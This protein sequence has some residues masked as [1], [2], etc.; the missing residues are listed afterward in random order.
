[1]KHKNLTDKQILKTLREHQNILRKY[2]VK[3][4]GLFGSYVRGK[5]KKGSDIDFL[6][7]FIKPDFDNFMDLTFFLED[8]F[9]KRVEVLTR[10]GVD[11]I[12]IK[13]VAEEIKRSV[14]YV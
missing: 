14:V 12:R 3:R 10:D 9:G 5:Q 4:I 11:T 8:L 2:G 1:M 7:E 6:V 13:E